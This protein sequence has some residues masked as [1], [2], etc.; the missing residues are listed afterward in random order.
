M[1]TPATTAPRNRPG[2]GRAALRVTLVALALAG[3][4]AAGRVLF[5]ATSPASG[6]ERVDR[7]L[8]FLE[9]AIN[10][11]APARMQELFPEGEFFTLV[12]T[13]L[14]E[15][16]RGRTDQAAAL[17]TASGRPGVADRFGG[18]RALDHG[19]FYRGWRLLLAAEIARRSQG[20]S[21]QALQDEADA[22]EAALL[23]DPA[24]VPESYPGGRW[25]CDAVVAMAAVVRTHQLAGRPTATGAWLTRLDAVRDPATGLLPHRLDA[26]T[27]AP[28]GSSQAIIQAFWSAVSDDPAPDWQRFK[29]LFLSRELGLVGVREHP[30]GSAGGGNVDSGPLV[31]G[32]SASASAVT[33]AA[34]RAHGDES[35]AVDLDREAEL[36][37]LPLDQGDGRR[38]AFGLLPVGD[39]WVAWARTTTPPDTAHHG[40]GERALLWA[41]ALLPAAVAAAAGAGLWRL[42]CRKA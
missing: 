2:L 30:I 37:G 27:T 4:L 38:F 19:T 28:Q 34:A 41:W 32:V 24:G 13:G 12:L 26:G 5:V 8:A 40:L 22:I 15:A 1:P 20:G 3:T 14:A 33:L 7:Q 35:L 11:G 16:N 21:T 23:A 6:P 42:R 36:L 39:A 9:D 18:V 17:L 10:R 31:L 25:P 29:Q